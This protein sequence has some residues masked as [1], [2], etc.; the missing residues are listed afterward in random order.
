MDVCST[1]QKSLPLPLVGK[2]AAGKQD[3]YLEKQL[4]QFE[5]Q[6]RTLKEVLSANGNAERAELLKQHAD[7]E[8]CVLVLSLLD[9]VSELWRGHRRAGPG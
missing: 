5:W 3:V 6:L 1:A 9:K 2:Q 7:E 4:E 8:V